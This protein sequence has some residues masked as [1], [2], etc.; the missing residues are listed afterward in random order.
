VR[1]ITKRLG[2]RYRALRAP[3]V[4]R[5]IE[6]VGVLGERAVLCVDQNI[7][8]SIYRQNP[9]GFAAIS[10]SAA[11]IRGGVTP[12]RCSNISRVTMA[13]R[14][15]TLVKFRSFSLPSAYLA[16]ARS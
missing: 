5:E 10:E 8:P 9:S 14:A 4:A 1:I 3:D 16:I 7:T 6:D 15:S 11:Q 2:L 13:C 12:R